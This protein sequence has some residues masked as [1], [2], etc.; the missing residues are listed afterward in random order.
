MEVTEII[1]E[2]VRHH[3]LFLWYMGVISLVTFIATPVILSFL[4]IRIPADYF[5]QKRGYAFTFER[6]HPL[7]R[8]L[9]LASKNLAG[10]CFVLAGIAMLLLPGQG[11]IMILVGLTLVDF[12]GKRSLER[13]IVGREKVLATLNWMRAKAGIP[14]LQI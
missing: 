8:F 9:L 12:P 11:V 3:Q 6:H 4:I 7:V 13:R 1:S 2:W 5:L 10:I 14:P